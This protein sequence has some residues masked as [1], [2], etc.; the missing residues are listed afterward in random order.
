MTA[1][2]DSLIRSIAHILELQIQF[3]KYRYS[4]QTSTDSDARL[5]FH[6]QLTL[7]EITCILK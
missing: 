6:S 5:G 4:Q 7:R 2:W 3:Y 1:L